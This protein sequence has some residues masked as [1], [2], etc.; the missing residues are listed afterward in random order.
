MRHYFAW[1]VIFGCL[2]QIRWHSYQRHPD[3]MPSR[4]FWT[5]PDIRGSKDSA[6]QVSN[7]ALPWISVSWW[8]PGGNQARDWIGRSWLKSG[9]VPHGWGRELGM[10]RWRLSPPL[11][12]QPYCVCEAIACPVGFYRRGN[13]QA[14]SIP[15]T[16][17]KV[18]N[19]KIKFL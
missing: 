9:S 13:G 11:S 10:E 12:L 19:T 8:A 5:S 3:H 17:S 15:T 16:K 6:H 2:R 4:R 7:T 1:P 14:K 18:G